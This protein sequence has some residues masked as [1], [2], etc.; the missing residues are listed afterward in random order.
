M[1]RLFSTVILVSLTGACP[2][3]NE[4]QMDPDAPKCDA[5]HMCP[6]GQI[7]EKGVCMLPLDFDSQSSTHDGGMGHHADSGNTSEQSVILEA[8]EDEIEFGGQRLGISV[9]REVTISNTGTL[10]VTLVAADLVEENGTENQ[11][12]FSMTPSGV[13]DE[14]L[15]PG[16]EL[17]FQVTHT[18]LDGLVDSGQIRLIHTG[19]DQLLTVD[20]LAEFKGNPEI[21]VTDNLAEEETNISSFY[22]GATTDFGQTVSKTFWVRNMGSLDSVLTLSSVTITPDNAGFSFMSPFHDGEALGAWEA[23]L[24]VAPEELLD[25][26]SFGDGNDAGPGSLACPPGGV[27]C[28]D[29]GGVEACADEDEVPLYAYPVTIVYSPVD[30]TAAV[31]VSLIHNSGGVEDTQTN[32]VVTATAPGCPNNASFD[33]DNAQSADGGLGAVECACDE[34]F[35]D[36]NGDIMSSNSDGCEYECE[37]INEQDDPDDEGTDANCDGMDGMRATGLF[38]DSGGSDSNNGTMFLPL[39]SLSRAMELAFINEDIESIFVAGGTYFLDEQ[40]EII[41][42]LNIYGGYRD[43]F[44]YRDEENPVFI[45]ETST[46]LHIANISEAL[47]IERITL[48]SDDRAAAEDG[49]GAH[50][51]TLVLENSSE[52]VTLYR[53]NIEAGTGAAGQD[54]DDGANGQPGASGN[55]GYGSTGGN[56]GAP[57]GGRGGNGGNRRRG[58]GGS[59]GGVC[60]A[61]NTF[62]MSDI[63]YHNPAAV[64]TACVSG[65]AGGGSTSSGGLGCSDGDPIEHPGGTGSAGGDCSVEQGAHGQAGYG[66]GNFTNVAWSPEWGGAGTAGVH[67]AGGGGGGGGGGEDCSPVGC[68]LGYCGTG[69]GAGGGGA[70]GNGG[71]AGSGGQGGGA[72]IG[73]LMKDASVILQSS[74][75]STSRGGP[76]GQGGAGGLGGAGGAG[77][78]GVASGDDKEGSGGN[79][80]AGGSGSHG[81]CGGGGPGG[82]SV[83]VWGLGTSI[84]SVGTDVIFDIANGGFGASPKTHN[85]NNVNICEGA[86][87][88]EAGLSTNMKDVTQL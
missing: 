31:I 53:V 63:R 2:D 68:G 16:S 23:S 34:N 56:G 54:G 32:L 62:S 79:G 83:G 43:N 84:I 25:G 24:C 49:Y 67:G 3:V 71:G 37:F 48:V 57:N 17:V 22:I 15:Y 39:R 88:G 51:S 58:Y 74:T 81:G 1:F 7:C 86:V 14:V 61:A 28:L 73:I 38:V 65:Q 33:F 77:G 9:T 60:G 59:C 10:P 64:N 42:G 52:T 70:G 20:L 55:N 26:G 85:E 45:S 11:T 47:R 69:R 8:S 78:I 19:P 13:I 75:L 36:L 72:S 12:E 6:V 46:V 80:G 18:P 87:G 82:P 21:L 44:T 35:Y 50:T 40:V 5:D 66:W 4:V 30:T 29:F 41:N 27:S 76:G